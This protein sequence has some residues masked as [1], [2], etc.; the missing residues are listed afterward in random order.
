MIEIE[1]YVKVRVKGP[2]SELKTYIK[3]L[4]QSSEYEFSEGA[5]KGKSST[6]FL[7]TSKI[8]EHVFWKFSSSDLKH[9]LH[10]YEKRPKETLTYEVNYSVYYG[11]HKLSEQL[12]FHLD[13]GLYPKGIYS[14]L[15]NVF[16]PLPD[17]IAYQCPNLNVSV[18][19]GSYYLEEI[20]FNEDEM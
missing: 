2:K 4:K 10:L 7:L 1:N 19:W 8:Q 14:E 20:Y 15:V 13:K 17:A 11:T 3:W 12:E 9:Q 16:N 18:N 5:H 6:A